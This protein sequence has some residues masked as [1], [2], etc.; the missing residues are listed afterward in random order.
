MVY[1][2]ALDELLFLENEYM[3]SKNRIPTKLFLGYRTFVRLIKEM[4]LDSFST[5]IH[6]MAITITKQEIIRIR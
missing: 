3:Q 2:N 1:R 6:G 4:E 5:D